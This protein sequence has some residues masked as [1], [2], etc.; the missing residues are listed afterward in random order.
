MQTDYIMALDTAQALLGDLFVLARRFVALRAD[1]E[2][3]LLPAVTRVGLRLRRLRRE[4]SF[5]EQGVADAAAEMHALRE[6]WLARIEALKATALYGEARAAYDAN[7]QAAVARLLPRVLAA[8]EAVP[9][10]PFLHFGIRVSA[11]RRGPGSPPFIAS[12]ACV[13]R[14]VERMAAG[15][16]PT[17]DDETG[18]AAIA[19]SDDPDALDSPVSLALAA[20]DVPAAVFRSADDDQLRLFTPHLA[21]AFVPAVCQATDDGWWLTN[22]E[23]WAEFRDRVTAGLAARGVAALRVGDAGA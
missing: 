8:L 22:E 11:V 17:G 3:V 21:A 20:A 1:A 2:A 12:G 6:E 9:P 15:F 18:F 4:G 19:T 16:R 5:P 14:I 13:E 10:P 23:S 7:D